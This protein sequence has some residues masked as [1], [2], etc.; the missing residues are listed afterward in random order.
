M[1]EQSRLL[2]IDDDVSAIRVLSKVLGGLGEIRFATSGEEGIQLAVEKLPDL[3]LLDAEMPGMSGFDVCKSLK[4]DSTL[5]HVPVIFITSHTESEMEEAG[6]LLG[7]VDFI[8][9]PIRPA[10]VAARVKTHLNLK[11]ALDR[12]NHLAQTDGLTG[13]ANRRALDTA[14]Q[15][16]WFR[17]RRSKRPMSLLLLDI[18]YFKKYNDTYGHLAGDDCLI[19]VAKLLLSSVNRSV[20]MVARYGGEEFAL[21]LPETDAC[22]AVE[23]AEKIIANIRALA[24]PHAVTDNGIVTLSIGIASFCSS[25]RCWDNAGKEDRNHT[26]NP[27]SATDLLDVAD[28]ALY[29][30]KHAGRNRYSFLSIDL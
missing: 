17:C 18:D 4:S 28:R 22:G 10:I 15:K 12:L 29:T 26:T 23:I 7:A 11:L 27:H 16:E 8:G 1:N 21:L 19:S 5:Q 2:I 14:I 9:K 24:L 13:L 6:L 30:A 25:S 20:D 3:I